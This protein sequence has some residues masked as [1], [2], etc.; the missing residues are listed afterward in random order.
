MTGKW[1]GFYQYNHQ[2]AQ[3]L[4]GFERTFFIINIQSFDGENFKGTVQDD[5]DTGGMKEEG[6]VEGYVEGNNVFFIKLMPVHG[7]LNNGS[8]R[9]IKKKEKHPTLYY[10]GTF[11]NDKK[12]LTGQWKFRYS[13]FLLWGFIPVPYR[14][15]KG[16]WGMKWEG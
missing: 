16:E 6:I 12:E 2:E 14:P 10:T 15:G 4:N 8:Q 7:V 5:V 9:L 11:S 13:I 3:R 1:L